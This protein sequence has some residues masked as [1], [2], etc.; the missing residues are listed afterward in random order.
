VPVLGLRQDP[1]H[2]FDYHHTEADTLDKIERHDLD[3]NV[4]ALAVMAYLL[5][6]SEDSL[7]RKPVEAGAP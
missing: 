6:D 7:P 3:R 2:Y 1:T 5:A 4:A